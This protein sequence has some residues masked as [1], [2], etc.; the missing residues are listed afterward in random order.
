VSREDLRVEGKG[1]T[2]KGTRGEVSLPE[3]S[4][5]SSETLMVKGIGAVYMRE[6]VIIW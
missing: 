5:P 4:E 2:L 6:V 3:I 1:F